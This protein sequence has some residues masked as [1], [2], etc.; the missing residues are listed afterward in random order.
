MPPQPYEP[1]ERGMK[2]IQKE[3]SHS[4][5]QQC[6]P[7]GSKDKEASGVDEDVNEARDSALRL[8]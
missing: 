8:I 5:H 2:P 7:R 3:V 1:L 6:L 4:N